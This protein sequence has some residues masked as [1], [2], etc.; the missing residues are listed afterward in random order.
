MSNKTVVSAKQIRNSE[1]YKL[2]KDGILKPTNPVRAKLP[3]GRNVTVS[4]NRKKDTIT[5]SFRNGNG[6]FIESMHDIME[7]G[8]RLDTIKQVTP[9]GVIIQRYPKD[10]EVGGLVFSKDMEIAWGFHGKVNN[11]TY[12]GGAACKVPKRNVESKDAFKAAVDYIRGN[13]SLQAYK[14]QL[15]K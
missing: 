3:S 7:N 12:A 13:G 1:L 15:R 14:E 11:P 10:Y 4:I 5:K 6:H 2:V 8:T 9:K